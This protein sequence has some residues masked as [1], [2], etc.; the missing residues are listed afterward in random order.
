MVADAVRKI[1]CFVATLSLRKKRSGTRFVN[2]LTKCQRF[3]R[4]SLSILF[5]SRLGC[6]ANLMVWMAE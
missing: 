6:G 1:K 5:S 3:L 4:D 2:Y